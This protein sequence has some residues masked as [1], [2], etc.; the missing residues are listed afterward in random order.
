MTE[1]TVTYLLPI[2]SLLVGYVI[3]VAAC[4]LGFHAAGRLRK[5]K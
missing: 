5:D 2:G 1:T 4:L 3:G